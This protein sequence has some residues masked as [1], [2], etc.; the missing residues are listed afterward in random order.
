MTSEIVGNLLSENSRKDF[1][2]MA[3]NGPDD[4]MMIIIVTKRGSQVPFSRAQ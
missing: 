1:I 3:G 2:K 4:I